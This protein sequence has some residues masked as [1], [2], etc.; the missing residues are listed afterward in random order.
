MSKP[1][2]DY[3]FG[4]VPR[5][6]Q[7]NNAKVNEKLVAC[8][9]VAETVATPIV[10]SVQ[11]GG[12]I[13][14]G[15]APILVSWDIPVEVFPP[16]FQSSST[17]FT[18]PETGLYVINVTLTVTEQA[19]SVTADAGVVLVVNGQDAALLNYSTVG[20]NQS[21][22][23]VGSSTNHYKASD[24]ISIKVG[25]IFGS[26]ANFIYAGFVDGLNLSRL[27]IQKI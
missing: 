1:C 20:A 18:I 23:Y 24:T 5:D 9:T 16:S 15:P 17:V 2:F 11:T 21:A 10:A 19:G 22:V 3:A 26:S 6:L 27:A 8:Q 4:L 13:N 14:F 12:N 25:C 7:V